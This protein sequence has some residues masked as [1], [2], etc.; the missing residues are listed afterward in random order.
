M[1]EA[2]IRSNAV[3]KRWAEEL[4]ANADSLGQLE[5]AAIGT[6][7][8]RWRIPRMKGARARST[9][10]GADLAHARQADLSLRD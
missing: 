3:D 1:L 8:N 4:I 7:D 6:A 5:N 10:H 2:L 9:R